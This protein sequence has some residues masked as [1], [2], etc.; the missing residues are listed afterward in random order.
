MQGRHDEPESESW[1]MIEMG[2]GPCQE[3]QIGGISLDG[4]C[5]N[6]SEE[7]ALRTAAEF[8]RRN[9]GEKHLDTAQSYGKL[10]ANLNGQVRFAEADV[11]YRKVLEIRWDLLGDE[12]AIVADSHRGVADNRNAQNL[13]KDAEPFYRRALEQLVAIISP[14]GR[15][16]ATR[17]S[18]NV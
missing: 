13:Y 2:L 15:T 7:T 14:D 11:L 8:N 17:W 6:L 10:A 9:L 5:Y 1:L 4:R 18:S 3:R 12:Y 16:T